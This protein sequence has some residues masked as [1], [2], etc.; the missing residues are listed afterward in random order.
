MKKLIFPLFVILA[1]CNQPIVDKKP[2]SIDSLILKSKSTTDSLM[3][4]IPKSDKKVREQVQKVV[5]KIQF[6]ENEIQRMEKVSKMT[7]T[8]TIH[9]TIYITE[10]KNFW[11]K[12]KTKIDSAKGIVE[13][14]LEQK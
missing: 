11:G 3:V 12:T 6:M 10:K 13:D 14:S 1:S 4:M 8:I 9:D 2:D 7:K 5:D